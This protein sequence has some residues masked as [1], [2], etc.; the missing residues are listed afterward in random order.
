MNN[1][2]AHYTP[3]PGDFSILNASDICKLDFGVHIDGLIQDCAFTFS[4]SDIHDELMAGVKEATEVGIETKSRFHA[5]LFV[6]FSRILVFS[7][8]VLRASTKQS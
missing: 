5:N 2:A 8:V 3:N 6:F 1:V 4:F 7:R